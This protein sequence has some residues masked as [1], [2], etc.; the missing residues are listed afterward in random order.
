MEKEIE[1]LKFQLEIAEQ[2]LNE[3]RE[4]SG[5]LLKEVEMQ[6]I[7]IAKLE[8]ENAKLLK[9]QQLLT[10]EVS[11]TPVSTSGGNLSPVVSPSPSPNANDEATP[12]EPKLKQDEE[13]TLKLAE[14]KKSLN[15][16]TKSRISKRHMRSASF[17]SQSSLQSF[18]NGTLSGDN[19][20]NDDMIGNTKEKGRFEG[21]KAQELIDAIYDRKV[22][23]LNDQVLRMQQEMKKKD[24]KLSELKTNA[25]NSRGEIQNL[26][27]ELNELRN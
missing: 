22:Q 6:K 3:E 15:T 19:M 7:R 16:P 21:L 8:E 12:T 17:T 10:K 18:H 14:L 5:P 26:E 2:D 25:A 4:T 27:K 20:S 24:A 13:R 9:K 1:D 23:L 11:T